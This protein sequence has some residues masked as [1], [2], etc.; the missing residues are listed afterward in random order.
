MIAGSV[1]V[2][3]YDYYASLKGNGTSIMDFF[4]E[5]GKIESYLDKDAALGTRLRQVGR[6]DALIVPL[7]EM[8]RD[9]THLAFGLGI[10]NA[11]QSSLGDNFTGKYF[12]KFQPFL[13][14]SGSV[15][16][17]EIGLLGI[18]LAL[19]VDYLIYRDSRV[20]AEADEGI[21]GALAVGWAG[22]TVVI[23]MGT[24]YA[25]LVKSEAL[26]YL[27]WYFSGLVAA[28]RCRLFRRAWGIAREAVPPAWEPA[29][30]R[31]GLVV[32]NARHRL[33]LKAKY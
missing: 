32:Q 1:F 6:G 9:P 3:I 10:G 26:S 33:P 31:S 18:A 14:S 5:K 22:V 19:L 21:V 25:N 8:A 11:S 20:V 4:S 12:L 30:G 17:L 23:V 2:P 15:F 29:T 28:Q 7:R 27:F 13:K 24:F 16:I